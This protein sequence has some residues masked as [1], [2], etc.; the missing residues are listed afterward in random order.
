MLVYC[1]GSEL[2]ALE[3]TA[4]PNIIAVGGFAVPREQ[5]A[6]LVREVRATKRDLTGDPYVPIKWNIRD[7][8]EEIEDRGGP[9]FYEEVAAVSRDIR[10]RMLGA[11]RAA[12][13]T[14]FVSLIHAHSEREDVLR[15]VGGR[16]PRYCFVNFLQR[17]GLCVERRIA[18]GRDV[19][20]ILDW[21]PGNDRSLWEEEYRAGWEEGDSADPGDDSE[22]LSGPLSELGFRPSLLY[23][24]TPSNEGLQVADL[25]VGATREFVKFAHLG[26]GE[27]D[28]VGVQEFGELLPYFHDREGP[29]VRRGIAVAP[30]S[31]DLLRSINREID[32]IQ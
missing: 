6:K 4:V 7:L 30:K 23:G 15:D 16:L 1:D 11:L 18:G 31:S 28:S 3:E 19:Q 9:D 22:Y 5:R 27:I 17:V 2:A 13:G 25:V 24:T 10:S 12:D 20:M 8:R 29:V 32:R 14:C 21:P 26:E